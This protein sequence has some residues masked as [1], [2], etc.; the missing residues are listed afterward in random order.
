MFALQSYKD[1]TS[2]FAYRDCEEA[3]SFIF[4]VS[5]NHLEYVRHLTYLVTFEGSKP[6]HVQ[7]LTAV[8]G[9]VYI[10]VDKISTQ[11]RNELR[12][13][14]RGMAAKFDGEYIIVCKAAGR[15]PSI[16]ALHYSFSIPKAMES[17]EVLAPIIGEDNARRHLDGVSGLT[18]DMVL[19]MQWKANEDL[20]DYLTSEGIIFDQ[21]MYAL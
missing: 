21:V 20:A 11:I 3:R 6:T 15:D 13:L 4:P 18:D 12:M 7:S 9:T 1:L 10:Y 2:N 17:M 19:C 5:I 8:D 16:P 14:L